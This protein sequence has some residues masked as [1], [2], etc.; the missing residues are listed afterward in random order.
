MDVF[1]GA[2]AE[3]ERGAQWAQC[4]AQSKVQGRDRDNKSEKRGRTAVR[5]QGQRKRGTGSQKGSGASSEQEGRLTVDVGPRRRK[6]T[7]EGCPGGPHPDIPNSRLS[8][9]LR[10][11][12]GNLEE[13]AFGRKGIGIHWPEPF[14][15]DN[16]IVS[17]IAGSIFDDIELAERKRGGNKRG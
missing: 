3:K 14:Q 5:E 13:A 9:I 12:H 10:H 1:I 4:G 7:Q 2:A 11:S 16:L 15:G 6:G 8:Q 17:G